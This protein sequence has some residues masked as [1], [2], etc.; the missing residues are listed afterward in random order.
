MNFLLSFAPFLVFFVLLRAGSAEL[1]LWAAAAA[2]LVLTLRESLIERKSVKIIEA[3]S[4]VL[5]GGLALYTT[6]FDVEWSVAG[7]RLVV[8]S[9]LLLLTLGS[10]VLGAPFTLQYAKEETRPE[11]WKSPEFLA[12]NRKITL[13]WVGAFAVLV[14]ADLLMVY[15]PAIPKWIDIVATILAL[16]WAVTFTK[17]YRARST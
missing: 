10:L 12:A 13:V 9:G 17:H 16:I 1:G 2:A 4:A 5:F 8:D 14:L 7:V 3:G 15:V 6:M 11:V